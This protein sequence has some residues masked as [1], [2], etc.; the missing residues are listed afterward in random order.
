[1][2]VL[3]TEAISAR[4]HRSASSRQV[5]PVA[6]EMMKTVGNLREIGRESSVNDKTIDLRC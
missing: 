1:V 2:Y 5:R 6:N 4:R 3:M